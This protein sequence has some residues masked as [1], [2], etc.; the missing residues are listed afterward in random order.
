MLKAIRS[1]LLAVT[2]IV[3]F[4]GTALATGATGFGGLLLS[5]GTLSQ[6]VH[7]NAGEVKFQTKDPVDF[8]TQKFTFD[9]LGSSGWH[10]HPGIVLVTVAEGSLVRYDANCTATLYATGS[11][12]TESGDEAGIVRNESTTTT[13]VVYATFIVPAGA[14]VL[15]IDKANP[16]CLQN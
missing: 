5:R 9:P 10:A 2:L 12:F 8:V 13:A 4:A 7:Y 3:V 16:G 15:R 6:P 14:T 1:P 11:S